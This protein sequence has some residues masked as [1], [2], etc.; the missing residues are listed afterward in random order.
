MEGPQPWHALYRAPA[1]RDHVVQLYTDEAFL[2][3]AVGEFAG[4]GLAQG[5]G[6]VLIATPPHLDAFT[7]ALGARLDVDAACARTQLV[8]LDAQVCLDRFMR[9]GRPDAE[10][11]FAVIG[12][13]LDRV[14]AAGYPRVRLFGEMVDLLWNLDLPATLR[15]E[16]LWSQVLA[17]RGLSLLCAYRID[18]F[19]RRAHRDVLHAISGCHSHL[20]PVE[21]YARLERAV[22]HAYREVFGAE[23]EPALL[24]QLFARRPAGSPV[25]PPAQAALLGLREIHRDVAED[26]LER[27][28]QYYLRA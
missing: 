16:E 22:D 8:V 11:F 28:R 13:V 10:K 27:A 24:R 7:R 25:M 14:G 1:P 3:R 9:G 26:V 17:A 4:A 19:D 6:A 21:D 23:S 12:G 15:L 5:E 20:V 18:N 2:T